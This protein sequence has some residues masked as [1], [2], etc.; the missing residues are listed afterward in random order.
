L[1]DDYRTMGERIVNLQCEIKRLQDKYEQSDMMSES[2]RVC[3]E[4]L[5]KRIDQI[6][7]GEA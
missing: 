5:Q 7:K 4:A 2:L 3:V 6:R 1:T